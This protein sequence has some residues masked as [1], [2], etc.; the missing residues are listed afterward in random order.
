[1]PRFGSSFVGRKVLLAR[2]DAELSLPGLLTVFGPGGAGKTRLVCEALALRDPTDGGPMCFAELAS[3][4]WDQLLEHHLVSLLGI[5]VPAGC[6]PREEIADRLREVRAVLVLD[7]CEAA[8]A[9]VESL[10]GHLLRVCPRL[11]I[12]ATSRSAIRIADGRIIEV[13]ALTPAAFM[14]SSASDMRLLSSR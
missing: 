2:L 9:S 7:S 6:D 12:V 5:R 13:S 10:V 8:L 11:T 4:P 1:M 3:L 14:K